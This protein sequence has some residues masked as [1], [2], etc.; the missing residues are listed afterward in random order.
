MSAPRVIRPL[1]PAQILDLAEG[2]R[3]SSPSTFAGQV[4]ELLYPEVDHGAVVQAAL[5]DRDGPLVD[6]RVSTFGPHVSRES[7]CPA[8]AES[9]EWGLEF[10]SRSDFVADISCPACGE[11]WQQVIDITEVL[12]AD[13]NAAA[14]RLLDEVAGL[15]RVYGWSEAEILQM[16][17]ARRQA[18][19][20]RV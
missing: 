16:S 17:A 10:V 9:L 18:Y 19:L 1:T 6:L 4:L 14:D 7:T 13:V 12:R 3:G 5:G 8:C 15:A 11:A 20:S 2:G